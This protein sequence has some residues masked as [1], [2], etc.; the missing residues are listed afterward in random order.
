MTILKRLLIAL[1]GL[2]LLLVLGVAALLFLGPGLHISSLEMILNVMTGRGG[3]RPSDELLARLEAADGYRVSVYA[4][5]LPHPRL[6]ARDEA[7]NLLVSNPR[8]GEVIL[9]ADSNG[10]GAADIRRLV[11]DNLVRP[12]GLAF[13]DG[14]LYVAESSRVGRAPWNPAARAVTGDYAVIADGFTDNGNHWSKSI[15]FGPPPS[16]ASRLTAQTAGFTPAGCATASAWRSRPGTAASM[17]P[18]TAATCW[19]TTTRPVSS[20]G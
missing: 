17:P 12:Q 19:G 16:C 6:L 9:L 2:T 1:G 13:H 7:G 5:D 11:L 14:Y 10:D 3:T 4:R 18:T 20:I 15:A 8:S